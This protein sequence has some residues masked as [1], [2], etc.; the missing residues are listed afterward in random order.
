MKYNILNSWLKIPI[1]HVYLKKKKEK[2]C[3]LWMKVR[4]LCKLPYGR[5]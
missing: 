4:W 3:P 1:L 2:V 5:D